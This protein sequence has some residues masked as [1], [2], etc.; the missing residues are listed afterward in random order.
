MSRPLFKREA[1]AL[2]ASLL[3]VAT[4]AQS[5][6]I[7][8][9][10]VFPATLAIDDP[11][12][13]DELALPTFSYAKASNFDGSSGATSYTFGG[14]FQKTITSDLSLSI[15]S[16]GVTFQRNP[17]A[18][19][20]SNIETQAKYVFYQNPER[21][22]I[23]SG[24]VNV[25]IG[26]TGSSPSSALP[27]DPFSTVTPMLYLGK[28]FG[29]A[30][31][32]WMRPFAVTAQVGVSLPTVRN[33]PADGSPAPMVATYGAT[34]QYSLLYRNAFVQE[35][36]SLFRNLIPTFEGVLSTPIA[37]TGPS[38]PDDFSVH[39]TTGVVGP[40]LYYVG[41]TFEIGVMAE[42]PINRASGAHPG[43]MAIVDFFLDDI[44]PDTIGKPL[45]GAPQSR[46]STY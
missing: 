1:R 21:E 10:R 27:A 42:I 45:F 15:A 20:F 16:Q 7:V 5:H 32:E 30:P 18:T 2:A 17:R 38:S 12:V 33:N 44:A 26:R 39:M 13:N 3:C 37:N 11:G 23:V 28:G 41:R 6:T 19:G 14:A 35:V 9:N 31:V 4:A 29:D 24:A 34:L 8:G 40:A 22:F 36:P 25:E 43:V 46:R